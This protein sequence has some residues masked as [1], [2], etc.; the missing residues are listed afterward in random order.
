MY[1]GKEAL[2]N[3]ELL[4]ILLRTGTKEKSALELASDI[5]ALDEDGI[6]HLEDCSL[7]ELASIK[8]MGNAKACQVLAAVELGKRIAAHPRRMRA[9]IGCP[10]DIAE[11]VMEKMRYYKKEHFCVLLLDTKGRVIEENE[12]SVGDLNGAM[13][14]PREVFIQAIRRS[15]AAVALI[16]NH[17]SGDPAPS[18]EDIGVTERLMDSAEILGIKIV[19]HI[20]IGDG[21]YTSLKSEGLM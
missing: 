12:V 19:D 5:L 3:G 6:L 9:E 8:G 2:S 16:H 10:S 4:A 1:H 7:E 13:V 17:P 15:A 21:V 20:I 14:H 18:E 11:L